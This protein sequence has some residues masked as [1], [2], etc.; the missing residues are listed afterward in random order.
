MR[1]KNL[2][3][4]IYVY[5]KNRIRNYSFFVLYLITRPKLFIPL[6]KG[7]YLP[8]YIQYEWMRKLPINTFLDIGALDG[9]VAQTINYIAPNADIYVFEPIAQKKKLIESKIKSSKLI[10]ETLAISNYTG[11]QIFHEYNYMAASSFLKPNSENKILTKEI[12]KSYKVQVTTLDKYFEKK[13]LKKPIFIKM[14]TQGMENLIIEGG[15]K[16]LKQVSLIIIEASFVKSYEDQCLFNDVYESLTKLGFIYKG[17]MLDSHYYPIFGP[18]VQENAI[19]IKKGELPN[20][21]RK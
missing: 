9:N 11:S 15:Q 16:L 18:L 14:D 3:S 1:N 19:F 10:V 7:I 20:Y 21:F 2:F 6:S 17:G 13:K 5:F 8:Q 12:E 4:I